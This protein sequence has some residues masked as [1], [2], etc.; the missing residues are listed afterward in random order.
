MQRMQSIESLKPFLAT[1]RRI[2]IVTHWSPDGD[3]IGSSLGLSNYLL[4]AGH[5]SVVVVPND[6]P[7]FLW[8]M[9]G[10]ET[11]INAEK[12]MAKA[13]D[14]FANAEIIFCLDFNDLSRINV[15]G[16][17]ISTLNKPLVLIDHHPQPS[18]FATYMM[19]KVESS[20]T[21]ELIYEFIDY[22]DGLDLIDR[23][24]AN[25]LYAGIMTDTGSFRFPATTA[26]TH[27]VVADLISRGAEHSA[28][29]NRVYDDNTES[30]LRLLGY[31]LSE[32]LV[33]LPEFRTAFFT[34]DNEEHDRFA[35]KKGDTEGLVNYALT[36]KGIVFAAFFAEREG[37]IKCSFRSKGMFDVNVFARAN[38]SGGGHRNAAG[39]VSEQ[40]LEDVVKKF[41]ALLPTY[42]EQL[43]NS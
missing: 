36:I 12:T 26:Y 33:V 13:K 17:F 23:D 10:H 40:K 2:A 4:K 14:V 18:D 25:C 9:K 16:Q 31:S 21:C 29:Y 8:W 6:Y 43:K 37:K 15:L 30:R 34:L 32:K 42:I 27:R 7:E 11:V 24:I 39:G 38:F 22:F 20:S 1:P 3:A 35:Y 19:H 5:Q 28:V 41:K